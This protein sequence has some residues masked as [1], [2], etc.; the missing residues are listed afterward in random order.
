M[1]SKFICKFYISIMFSLDFLEVVIW[2]ITTNFFSTLSNYFEIVVIC[3]KPNKLIYVLK[4]L[5]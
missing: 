2:K 5:I 4:Y 1:K 3:K